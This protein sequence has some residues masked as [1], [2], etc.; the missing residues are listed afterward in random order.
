MDAGPGDQAPAR[1]RSGLTVRA[2]AAVA[3][4]LIL[5]AAARGAPGASLADTIER[6][7]PGIVVV[8]THAALRQPSGEF[9]GTGFA[10]ADGHHVLTNAHVLPEAAD[11]GRELAVFVGRGRRVEHRPATV[12]ARDPEHDL[13]L[14]RIPGEPLPALSLGDSARVRAGERYAF[15]GFPIGTVLGMYPVTH[16]ALVSSVTPIAVPRGRAGRLDAATIRRLAD[17]YEVFQLD[18]TAYPGNSGSPLYDPGTGVV[19]GVI[20]M[21]FVKRTKENVLSDPSG[22]AYA[23][24]IRHGRA[25]IEQAEAR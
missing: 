7:T 6:V 13:A 4:G 22:I 11:E 16:E 15:T 3:V 12:V 25:L 18:G 9:R 21:V 2:L 23:I 14:L 1:A 10:V 8:G 17:P 5:A 20:N 24:P 19:V